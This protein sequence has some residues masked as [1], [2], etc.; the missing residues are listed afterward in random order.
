MMQVEMHSRE[1]N[2]RREGPFGEGYKDVLGFRN[3]DLRYGICKW[4]WLVKIY[5]WRSE[6]L[7]LQIWIV[8]GYIDVSW[9]HWCR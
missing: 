7:E 4:R 2:I 6:A 5:T 8:I 3:A 9:S 1:E